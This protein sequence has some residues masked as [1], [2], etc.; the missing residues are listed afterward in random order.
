MRILIAEDDLTS[1]KML[2]I[3]LQKWGYGVVST[4]RGDEAFAA[5][6]TAGRPSVAILDWMMPGMSGIEICRK[7]QEEEN[8]NPVYV[9]LLTAL[10]DKD[11]VITGLRSGADDYVTKPFDSEELRARIRVG[12]R[13]VELRDRLSIQVQE[14]KTAL[15]HV[16][17]LQGILPICAHCHRIRDDRKSWRGMEEYIEAHSDAQFS[18]GIC[19]R[20]MDKYYPKFEEDANG[21]ARENQGIE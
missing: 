9:I 20:C 17:M 4:S 10:G 8:Q 5:L 21:Q 3:A 13:V 16:K 7:L 2:E 6:Q 18:H 19:P 15:A 11:A 14:L 1:R 12:E